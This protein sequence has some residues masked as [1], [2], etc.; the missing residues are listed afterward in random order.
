MS[1]AISPRPTAPALRV[2]AAALAVCAAA[3]LAK[4]QTTPPAAAS[5]P[6]A[7]SITSSGLARPVAYA[8]RFDFAAGIGVGQGVPLAAEFRFN[9]TAR[10]A[11]ALGAQ[12]SDWRGDVSLGRV[13]PGITGAEAE[14]R[15]QPSLYFDARYFPRA[16]R[17]GWYF[18]AGVGRQGYRVD[19]TSELVPLPP[20]ERG[21]RT[22][23]GNVGIDVLVA[24]FSLGS[25][26]DRDADRRETTTAG[27]VT[28]L[29]AELGYAIR[30]GRNM[31]VELGAGLRARGLGDRV[32]DVGTRD[33][34]VPQRLDGFGGTTAV[35]SVRVVMGL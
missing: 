12:T 20:A 24:L 33:G 30:A 4:A 21:T 10:L 2:L 16:D 26:R 11:L 14:L 8:P 5:A 7:A 34:T 15:G 29:R 19:A 31:R 9:P 17:T 22:S 6:P 3:V 35:A 1:P 25:G 23:S 13:A 28:A 27:T 32:Y 18:G